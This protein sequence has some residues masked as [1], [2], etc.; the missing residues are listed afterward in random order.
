M[1]YLEWPP[2]TYLIIKRLS[3]L[4]IQREKPEE[5]KKIKQYARLGIVYEEHKIKGDFETY[6]SYCPFCC[7][8]KLN[9][10]FKDRSHYHH[11]II[12]RDCCLFKEKLSKLRDELFI[13]IAEFCS[14]SNIFL[15]SLCSP[16]FNEIIQL[17][18]PLLA[19]TIKKNILRKKI[20]EI[21]QSYLNEI[22]T[23]CNEKFCSV[24]IDGA[25]RNNK[26]FYAFIIFTR[27]RLFFFKIEKI[28]CATTKNIVDIF[29][30]ILNFINTETKLELI[31][32]CTDHA[33]N[34]IK[35][36]NPI[37]QNSSQFKNSQF[38]EWVGCF[39]HLLNLGINDLFEL[40]EFLIYYINLNE[41]L[42]ICKSLNFSKKVP[43]FSKTR[44]ESYSKCI[45]FLNEM[46]EEINFFFNQ[47]I[48]NLNNN[49]EI[50][51]KYRMLIEILNS[52]DFNELM[53]LFNNISQMSAE[54][55]QDNFVICKVYSKFIKFKKFVS[56]IQ[57]LTIR[58]F[59]YT[60]IDRIYAS[61][62]IQ[63]AI[64]AFFLTIEG[65]DYFLNIND[66]KEKENYLSII[67][68]YI[69]R[70]NEFKFKF[71]QKIL[72]SQIDEYINIEKF[73]IND[74][75]IY[76]ENNIHEE[77][78]SQLSEIAIRIISMACSELAVERLFSHLKYLYRK[79]DYNKS[80][81]LLN[82]QLSIRMEKI[83]SRED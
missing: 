16:K 30:E 17:S 72:K 45:N 26:N 4:V 68:T 69:F 79:K 20:C 13:K 24:L 11:S 38:F 19:Q 8:K 60:I 46:K 42:S 9:R 70:Y 6:Y 3:N 41:I 39:S 55:G 28:N 10:H 51:E 43:G 12:C 27:E 35:A 53:Q 71:D 44:W 75:F 64:T 7:F 77:K 1:N 78:I 23:K 56:N 18:N 76:W 5:Y 65:R 54:I 31:S 2:G 61:Y 40:E 66:Q 37:D 49:A 25:K 52:S 32:V 62:E 33:S 50:I 59:G 47:E 15:N 58:T 29:Q 80:E 63:I 73:T 48:Q 74:S 57:S 83:Y 81:D 22:N 34:L 67:Q 82:A 14:L 21:G 36:F